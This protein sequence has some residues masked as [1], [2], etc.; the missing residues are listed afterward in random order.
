MNKKIILVVLGVFLCGSIYSDSSRIQD[1]RTILKK[2]ILSPQIDDFLNMMAMEAASQCD[3]TLDGEV[4]VQK[5]KA[6]LEEENVFSKFAMPFQS[7]S[8]EELT[9]LRKIHENPAYVKYSASSPQIFQANLET[10]K[11][12]FT[13]IAQNQGTP[14]VKK[15]STVLEIT[16]DNYQKEVEE[17]SKPVII[18][19]YSTTCPPCRI[20]EP[21]MEELSEEYK[22]S[23][24]FVKINVEKE[25]ELAQ[26]LGVTK[27]PTLLFL[28]AGDKNASFTSKGFTSK[29]DIQAKIAELLQKK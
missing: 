13:L 26:K 14:K 29:K 3:K 8:D 5:F 10:I 11:D 6:S 21:I 2:T 17:S 16:L 23:V 15:P 12:C 9:E 4:A 28:R 18:D 1:I 24:R 19:V 20:L 27:L 7:F 25:A 22:G